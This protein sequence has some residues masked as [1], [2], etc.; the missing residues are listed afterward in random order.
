M[1][2]VWFT[3]LLSLAFSLA[4]PIAIAQGTSVDNKRSGVINLDAA[5]GTSLQNQLAMI[6]TAVSITASVI[7]I[8]GIALAAY[9]LI[10]SIRMFKNKS[11]GAKIRLALAAFFLVQGVAVPGC[12]YASLIEGSIM[13]LW[14]DLSVLLFFCSS[15][16]SFAVRRMRLSLSLS[17]AATILIVLAACWISRG[18]KVNLLP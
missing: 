2:A 4:C 8:G 13:G 11:A 1:F 10:S 18:P 16:L 9:C 17:I 12:F 6:E 15:V 14:F 3:M 5:G 7:E